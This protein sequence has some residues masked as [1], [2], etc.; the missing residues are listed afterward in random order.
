MS[1]YIDFDLDFDKEIKKKA[2]QEEKPKKGKNTSVVPAMIFSALCTSLLIV[3]LWMGYRYLTPWGREDAMRIY[4]QADMDEA[5]EE[6]TF[7]QTR[8]ME[9][10]VATAS[11]EGKISGR[12]GLLADLKARFENGETTTAILKKLYPES[13]VVGYENAYHFVP[14]TDSLKHNDYDIERMNLD[15]ETGIITYSNQEGA[16]ISRKGIDVSSHQGKIDWAAV[17]SDGVEF[18]IVRTLYRGYESGALVEDT[19]YKANIEGAIKNKIAVGVYVFTQAITEEEAI[20]EADKVLEQV[21]DYALKLPIVLDVERVSSSNGRFNLISP[22]ER[23]KIVRTFCDRIL[24]AGK[25]P[26]L[27]YNT[28]MGALLLDISQFTDLDVWFAAYTPDFYWPYEYSIWQYSSTGSVKGIKG[29]VDLNIMMDDKY[30][31]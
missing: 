30:L 23:T 11:E 6:I 25:E 22:E 16:V 19:F 7:E 28:Q 24:A 10:R 27:Y 8:L 9:E 2:P 12:S 17:A 18:A 21:K 20:E 29:T 4:T 1:D 31:H 5:V 15:E 14:I 3:L 13:I 26:M